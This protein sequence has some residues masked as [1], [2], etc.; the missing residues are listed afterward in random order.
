[1]EKIKITYWQDD[2]FWLG[3]LNEYP[4]YQTQG[5]TFEELQE[6]LADIYND[7]KNELIPGIRKTTE[8]TI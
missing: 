6:N 2:E 4:E 8:I 3:Y 7:I 1:M 5:M